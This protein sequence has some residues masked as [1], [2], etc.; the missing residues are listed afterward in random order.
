MWEREPEKGE[1]EREGK[2]RER[3]RETTVLSTDG[4]PWSL[5]LST[6]L[7]MHGRKLLKTTGKE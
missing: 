1:R 4:P 5:P 7:H 2:G 3:K 6:D